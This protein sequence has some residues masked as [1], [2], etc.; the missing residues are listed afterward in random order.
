LAKDTALSKQQEIVAMFDEI[1]PTY[2]IANRVLSVGIDRSWRKVAVEKAF[3][4]LGKRDS[5][6]IADVA[7]GTGD[8]TRFWLEGAKKEG[9]HISSIIGIDPSVKMLEKAREKIK[10]VEFKEGYATELGLEDSSCDIVSIVYG[11]RNVVERKAALAEFCRVLKEGGIVVILEFTKN[12]N[13][14]LLEKVAGFYK[15]KILPFVGGLISG[16]YKAYKYLPDSI[17][18]FLSAKV[19]EEELKGAGLEPL[20]TKGYSANISTT[21]I[22]KKI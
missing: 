12:E 19:L 18:G 2:D 3:D 5:V 11:L 8:M 16:N 20:F 21:I 7:C 15:N 1:A 6:S 13:E 22:A 4:L 10:E 17:E 14:T 9:V